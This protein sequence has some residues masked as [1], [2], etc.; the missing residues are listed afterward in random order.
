MSTTTAPALDEY[1]WEV[2]PAAA[3]WVAQTVDSLAKRNPTIDRLGTLLRDHTGTRLVDWLDHLAIQTADFPNVEEQLAEIGY[4][5][6]SN[7]DGVIW[8]QPRGMFPP[9]RLDAGHTG[10]AIRCDAIDDCLAALP[11]ALDLPPIKDDAVIGARGGQ[12]RHATLSNEGGVQ[13]SV[14]ERH[15]YQGFTPNDA[16][17]EKIS[18]ASRHLNAFR[19]RNRDSSSVD[20]F[21]E[22]SQL[23]AA[24]ANEIGR[25]WAC[26][27]FF[28]SEREYWQSRN[29]AA[30]VQY[31][32]Q[33]RL[34]LGWANHDHHTYRSSRPAFRQLIAIL[35]QMGFHCRE[36]FYAGEEAGWGAQ[37]LEQPECRI[38]IFADVDMSAEE[39]MG[40]FS[41]DG[42]APRESFGTVGLWC[43]LHGEAFLEAGMHHLECQ[44]DFDAS[45]KQLAD[46]GVETL[47]PFT[48]FTFL[49]Q[50]FT[51]GESWKVDPKRVERL[52]SDGHITAEQA[53][54]FR[55]DGA[56]GSHLEIL[57]RNDGYKGFNQ[58]GVSEIILRTDPRRMTG[59]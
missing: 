7:G 20:G 1:T 22:A 17:P 19:S 54:R 38:V 56:L 58:T 31:E 4:A 35:E 47:A 59:A 43:E 21:K 2:Q 55:R 39:L 25:A 29:R 11:A 14:I 49:R 9:V 48:D 51:R 18:A 3:R 28:Q 6:E 34:G 41:H 37:V 33:Q 46:A 27:L 8:R 15:G 50:A 24:A 53:D 57:E 23:F 44:F 45:R 40:D 16:A 36:R 42:L 32:R 12:F 13:L 30:R 52:L 26:D 5:S 10:V